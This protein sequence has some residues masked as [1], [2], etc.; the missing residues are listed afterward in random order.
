[1]YFEALSDLEAL[2]EVARK[3]KKNPKYYEGQR[4]QLSGSSKRVQ[5]G[6]IAGEGEE[7]YG[8]MRYP[9]LWDGNDRVIPCFAFALE[10]LSDLEA[11]AEVARKAKKNPNAL[12]GSRIE[13]GAGPGSSRGTIRSV[14]KSGGTFF[15]VKYTVNMDDGQIWYLWPYEVHI[16]TPL[17]LLAEVAN[18]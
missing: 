11:L 10:P 13:V 5:K 3:A 1:M 7:Q 2:A 14:V 6:T 18:T 8:T 9:V 17:E 15:P 16:L 4:V 12:V